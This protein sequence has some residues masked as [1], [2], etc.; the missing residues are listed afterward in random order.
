MYPVT[1]PTC[2]G[3]GV[4]WEDETASGISCKRAVQIQWR[5]GRYYRNNDAEFISREIDLRPMDRHNL[6]KPNGKLDPYG[7]A[8]WAKDD[9]QEEIKAWLKHTRRSK[10]KILGIAWTGYAQGIHD[11][12]QLDNPL[13][14]VQFEL[15]VEVKRDKQGTWSHVAGP[16]LNLDGGW[17]PIFVKLSRDCTRIRYRVRFNTRCDPTNTVLLESPI[18]D[19]LTIYYTTRPR[20]LSWVEGY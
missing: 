12:G 8:R 4:F 20:F 2:E 19:D 9:W 14:S 15:S 5:M 16:F 17:A 13:L 11:Y 3:S 7:K 10:P 1:C 18:L 6:A